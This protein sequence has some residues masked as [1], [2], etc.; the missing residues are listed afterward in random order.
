MTD[1]TPVFI[2]NQFT[3]LEKST[4]DMY[5]SGKVYTDLG[6][7][8]NAYLMFSDEENNLFFIRPI[9]F[10][11]DF[12]ADEAVHTFDYS[13][14]LDLDQ[15][16]DELFKQG[17]FETQF[18]IELRIQFKDQE[19]PYIIAL[20]SCSDLNKNNIDVIIKKKRGKKVIYF[21]FNVDDD[22][23]IFLTINYY[24]KETATFLQERT[25]ILKFSH[26]LLLNKNIW[27][28]GGYSPQ[29]ESINTWSFFKFL[30]EN[31][32]EIKSY[33]IL[34]E[35]AP[36]YKDAREQY[37]DAILAY[38]S[39][40]Y[41]TTLIRSTVLITSGCLQLFYPITSTAYHQKLKAKKILLPGSILGVSNHV[42]T[43]NQNSGHS[44]VDFIITHS[45]EE[46]E[47]VNLSMNY[48]GNRILI[49]GSPLADEFLEQDIQVMGKHSILMLPYP[50]RHPVKS[51]AFSTVA[52]YLSLV[53]SQI[54]KDF[55]RRYELNPIIALPSSEFAS[56]ENDFINENITTLEQTEDNILASFY[57][58][59]VV[60]SNNHP[61][62]TIF[63]LSGRPV[64]SYEPWDLNHRQA[65][66]IESLPLGERSHTQKDL[67]ALLDETART[68]FLSKSSHQLPP[69]K[70][71]EFRDS[72]SNHRIFEILVE[73][74]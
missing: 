70:L 27:V 39:K 17:V 67:L 20:T 5:L 7:V 46:A 37:G 18:E 55:I 51:N 60:I 13:S 28:M 16:S 74:L 35:D 34:S 44:P 73:Q 1:N 72:Q 2:T 71:I 26:P 12:E 38:R 22:G 63:A 57:Y 42:Y 64:V 23:F 24:E 36:H 43:F 21:S 8:T 69:E 45:E 54:F 53:K 32:T 4:E 48:D 33:Y 66:E 49:A 61:M 3:H 10:N 15:I 68:G 40:N 47:F 9:D 58:S 50:R 41:I 29:L 25:S 6:L 62:V 52:C 56:F 31:H 11:I 30:Q 59:M 14:A 19:T 65:F